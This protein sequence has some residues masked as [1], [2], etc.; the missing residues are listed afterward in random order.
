MSLKNCPRC[1]KLFVVISKDICPDCAGQDEAMFE[2]VRTYIK[3]HP[4]CDMQE[5]SEKTEVPVEKIL[6]YLR[7]GKI[8]G[9]ST[10]FGGG[11][12]CLSCSAPITTGRLCDKCAKSLNQ[13]LTGVRRP[14]TLRS[15]NSNKNIMHTRKD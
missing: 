7:E 15:E 1:G 3:A 13:E 14:K 11:L 9:V 5:V 10:G 4:E 2:K 8:I 12:Q 6:L